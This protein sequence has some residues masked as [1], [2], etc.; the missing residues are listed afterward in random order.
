[1]PWRLPDT[2]P[3]STPAPQRQ[4]SHWRLWLAAALA[5][6]VWAASADAGTVR[7]VDRAASP[8]PDITLGQVAQLDGADARAL[9]HVVVGQFETDELLTQ[10]DHAAIRRALTEVGANWA[11]LS[12]VGRPDCVVE[13]RLPRAAPA[14]RPLRSTETVSAVNVIDAVQLGGV[15]RVADRIRDDIARQVGVSPETLIL[16][17]ANDADR[18]AAERPLIDGRSRV[19]V[20]QAGA[21]RFLARVE[22]FGAASDADQP[23]LDVQ[24]YRLRSVPMVTGKVARGQVIRSADVAMRSVE[25]PLGID[26]AESLS[27][28]VGQVAG[29]PLREGQIVELGDVRSPAVVKRRDAVLVEARVGGLLVQSVGVAMSDGAVG[30]MIEVRRTDSRDTFYAEVVG[31][32]R[33]KV[34]VGAQPQAVVATADGG[35]S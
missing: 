27:A 25:A 3:R 13:R 32:R 10:V 16:R 22:P 17:Y 26:P 33:A 30:E 20:T 1:M 9:G 15:V 4:A 12:L 5:V 24:A 7:L 21:S 14:P 34:W 8:G 2:D 29:R 23:T 31:P 35:A 6:L 18:L 19:Y 11:V 28:V